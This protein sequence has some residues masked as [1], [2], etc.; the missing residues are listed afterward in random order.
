MRDI[1]ETSDGNEKIM[2]ATAAAALLI[3]PIFMLFSAPKQNDV[4]TEQAQMT[5]TQQM[6]LPG[7]SKASDPAQRPLKFVS[8]SQ[9]DATPLAK[10]RQLK[11]VRVTAEASDGEG[12]RSR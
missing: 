3:P 9:T 12:V 6:K 1:A 5:T 10:W 7:V 2:L 8:A 4:P 11:V